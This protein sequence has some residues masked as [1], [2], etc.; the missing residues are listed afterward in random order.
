MT[1]RPIALVLAIL[2]LAASRPAASQESPS[3]SLLKVPHGFDIPAAMQSLFGNYDPKAEIAHYDIPQS[4]VYS[5]K[6][7]SF[8]IGDDI[9]VHPLWASAANED[10]KD[11]VVFVFY[12]LPAR[13]DGSPANFE[14][15]ACTPLIGAA[16]FVK[17]GAQWRIESSRTVVTRSGGFGYPPTEIRIITIGPKRIGIEITDGDTGG[18]ETTDTKSIL[19]PWNG[20]IN[21]A[22]FTVISDDNKGDCGK[23]ADNG[24][25]YANRKSL[26][27]VP[28]AN[29]EYFDV[30][31]RLSGTDMTDQEPY[32][33]KI[34]HGYERFSFAN[35]SYKTIKKTGEKISAERFME[36]R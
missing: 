18:G 26:S 23:D 27:F 20:K 36:E 11:K 9:L 10:G 17:D 16:I 15:H 4:T 24:P 33:R 31:L 25:C 35:G 13:D 3:K 34:V 32:R 6:G 22:L 14:C 7:S 12:S 5:L 19:V 30:L 21:E 29:P 2:W 8:E 28:G 1:K